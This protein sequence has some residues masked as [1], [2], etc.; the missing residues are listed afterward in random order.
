MRITTFVLAASVA[1]SSQTSPGTA[2][3][4][5][6]AV[7]ASA[8]RTWDAAV[9][10]FAIRGIPIVSMDS[11]QGIIA[12]AWVGV[13][14]SQA[15]KWAECRGVIVPGKRF[16]HYGNF[17][18]RAIYKVIVAG[19]S[20]AS[21]VKVAVRWAKD[22]V[23]ERDL[24][25]RTTD[26]CESEFEA[27]IKQGAEAGVPR[28]ATPV[29]ASASRA[30]DAVVDVLASRGFPIRTTDRAR[31]SIAVDES[32]R[33]DQEALFATNQGTGDVSVVGDSVASKVKVSIRWS[34]KGV[35]D[36]A[37]ERT[38]RAALETSLETEIREGA[39]TTVPRGVTPVGAPVGRTWDAVADAFASRG[40]P[41]RRMERA[42]GYMV[43]SPVVVA[44]KQ[45][46]QWAKDDCG[47]H[48]LVVPLDA[49]RATYSAVVRGNNEASTVRVRT[50]WTNVGEP[51]D[52]QVLECSTTHVRESELEA[53]IKLGAETVVPRDATTIRAAVDRTWNAAVDVLASRGIP[54]ITMDR[55]NGFIATDQLSIRGK[56]A[57]QWSDCFK[58]LVVRIHA[59]RAIY[60]VFVRG[61]SVESTVMVAIHWTLTSSKGDLEYVE[62][63]SRNVRE[64]ELEAAIK[65]GAEA[66]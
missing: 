56:S 51:G 32:G 6:T 45:A 43:T 49:N 28:E 36:E 8:E 48:Y 62:C 53:A 52:T 14:S 23:P 27:A 10:V 12:T 16:G 57:G 18:D 66:H 20:V 2:P 21:T 22:G 42:G 19:D 64:S 54:I 44:Y 47:T 9:E 46:T 34:K 30:W 38:T 13:N 41:I 39:E 55:A 35:A 7:S 17:A 11:D 59:D 58:V 33:G 24:E 61:D 31:G 1:A 63:K 50:R 40:I 65:A 25:C 37:T 4:V 15:G 5:A 60:N 26:V 29:S 3:D